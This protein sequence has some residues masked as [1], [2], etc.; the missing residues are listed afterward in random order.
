MI[1]LLY[2]LF[3]MCVAYPPACWEYVCVAVCA[4]TRILYELPTLLGQLPFWAIYLRY[5]VPLV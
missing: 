1:Y 4:V 3:V 2:C 5:T